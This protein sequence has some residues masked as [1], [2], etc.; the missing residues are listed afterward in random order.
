MQIILDFDSCLINILRYNTGYVIA[1]QMSRACKC[2]V[3]ENHFSL[4][5]L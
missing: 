4:E 1:L 2:G 3:E 5:F